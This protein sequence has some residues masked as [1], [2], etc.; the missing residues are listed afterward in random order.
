M[1]EYDHW[2]IIPFSLVV[3]ILL[4]LLPMPVWTVWLRPVWVLMVLIYWTM[5]M[6]YR[7]NVG[8]A[9]IMGLLLDVLNG[10]LLGEHALALTVV[11]YFVSKMHSQLRMYPI[12]QQ[13]FWVL[14]FVLLYQF[15]LFCVQ[16]FLGELPKTWLYWSTSLTSML[17][18]PWIFVILRDYRRRFKAA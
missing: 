2:L 10:T 17:L 15:A 9:W 3:A 6:P 8:T 16:G 7:V 18:W 5:M 11:I 12:L 1:N 14:L 13:S 4:T